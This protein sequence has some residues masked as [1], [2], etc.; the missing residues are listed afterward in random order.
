MN[1]AW[2]PSSSGSP[3]KGSSLFYRANR[4]LYQVLQDHVPYLHATIKAPDML[5]CLGVRSEVTAP[6]LL[7]VLTS[8]AQQPGFATSLQHMTQVQ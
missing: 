4:E 5:A 7:E 3:S 6:M 1:L 2:L 8:W